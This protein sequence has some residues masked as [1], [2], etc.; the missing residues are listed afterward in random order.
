M[1]STVHI[2]IYLDSKK[3]L[4][5]NSFKLNKSNLK[6]QLKLFKKFPV[7]VL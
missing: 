3:S 4:E 5:E 1:C 7:I 2:C 6:I